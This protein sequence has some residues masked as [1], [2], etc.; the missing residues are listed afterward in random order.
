MK[1]S[2]RSLM[3]VVV[4]A[5]IVLGRVAHLR[6]WAEYHDRQA[7]VLASEL[8]AEY[9]WTT[10]SLEYVIALNKDAPQ[11]TRYWDIANHRQL[12]AEYWAATY[13]PWTTVTEREFP[14]SGP[15]P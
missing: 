13:R 12:A 6:R 5:A 15:S 11:R 8:R 9:G 3:V 1:Y 2:L 4:V 7:E 10:N 14:K